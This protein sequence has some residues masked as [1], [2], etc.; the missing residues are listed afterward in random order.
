MKMFFKTICLALFLII[1]V[2]CKQKQKDTAEFRVEE[3]GFYHNEIMKDVKKDNEEEKEGKKIFAA[4]L[5]N[6]DLPKSIDEFNYQWHN[7]PISQGNSGM[8]WSFSTTSFFE[9]EVK[10]IHDKEVKLSELW[11]V[12]WEYIEKT[13]EYINTKG[14]SLFA[15]GSEANALQRIY[16]Q[17]GIVP[18]D[19]YTGLSSDQKFHQHTKMFKEMESY[20]K[21]L[22]E[23]NKWDEEKA[24]K[25][26]TSILNKHLGV[27]PTSVNADGK[28]YSPKE[29]LTEYLKLNVSDYVNILSYLQQPFYE[30]VEYEVPDNWWDSKDYYNVPLEEFMTTIK[31]A[32]RAGY[33]MTIGGDVS[34]PGKN[35]KLDVFVIPTFD[36]PSEYID[37]YARQFR[38]Y[39]KTTQDDHGIH[40]VGFKEMDDVDWYMIKDSGAGSRDGNSKGYYFLHEDYVKLKIMDFMIHKDAVKETLNKF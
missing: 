12:Y 39:N 3:K 34:E 1:L 24:I 32:V 29:Y 35:A 16:N 2:S 6:F 33:T 27:P 13:K 17:Y 40:L 20:L 23:K 8:C 11:T 5:D 36:I 18:L 14:E 28:D 9:S 15:Q 21:T 4:N 38:F 10:R 37:D 31:Y 19:S 30:Q 25:N 7:E 26:I 22:K